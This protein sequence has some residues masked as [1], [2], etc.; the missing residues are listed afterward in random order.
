MKHL[1]RFKIL[2]PL[3]VMICMLFAGADTA[4]AAEYGNY[5]SS[6]S[7]LTVQLVDEHKIID[8]V[9][10][11]EITLVKTSGTKVKAHVLLV[12]PNAKA[13][14]KPVIPGY[15]TEGST[16]ATRTQKAKAW[17]DSSFSLTGVTNMIKQYE[18]SEGSLPVIAAV[19]GDFSNHP[20]NTPNGTATAPRGTVIMEGNSIAHS[21]TASDE[22]LFG[23]KSNGA[24]N[25]VGRTTSQKGLFEEAICGGAHILR[26]GSL[27]GVDNETVSDE[28][29]GIAIRNNGEVLLIT[30]ENGISVKQLAE[31]MQASGC[32]NGINMDGGGSIHMSTKRETETKLSRK[33]PLPGS[34][35]TVDDNGERQVTSALMLVA[36]DSTVVNNVKNVDTSKVTTDKDTYVRGE[37]I[38]VT[39]ST[40]V[41]GAWVSL[42][43]ES[44]SASA[45]SYFWYYVYGYS[46]VGSTDT[47]CW[48][49]GSTY[50]ILNDGI[51]SNREGVSSA[52]KLPLGKY[53]VSVL[54]YAE[55]GGYKELARSETITIK[56]DES[57]IE[58]ELELLDASRTDKQY[59]AT[60]NSYYGKTLY[61]YWYGD[62]IT[63]KASVEGDDSDG[64]WVGIVRD[65]TYNEGG[66]TCIS[67]NW[68]NVAELEGEEV[69]LNYVYKG[70]ISE[71]AKNVPRGLNY[72]AVLVSKTG[73]ILDAKPF[74]YRTYCLSWLEGEGTWA[75]QV[76]KNIKIE[77]RWI[78]K[79]VNGKDQKPEITITRINGHFGYEKDDTGKF[80]TDENGDFIEIT[81]EILVQ[82]KDYTVKYPGESKLAGS[83]NIE[84]IF[85]E[86]DNTDKLNY[87]NDKPEYYALKQGVTYYLTE[88]SDESIIE[89]NLNGGTNHKDNPALYKPGAEVKL[90]SPTRF[91]YCFDGWYTDADFSEGS[92][93]DRISKSDK[94]YMTLYAKWVLESEAPE[95]NTIEYVLYG[96]D[97][98]IKNPNKYTGSASINLAPAK[99]AGYTF[100]GWFYDAKF[101]I[102]VQDNVI[103][104]N[105][106]GGLKLHAKFVKSSFDITTDVENGTITDG[107]DVKNGESFTVEYAADGG[108]MLK[109][110][111]VDGIAVDINAHP[112]SYTFDK[113]D[114]DHDISVVFGK[115]DLAAPS[116]LTLQLSTAKNGYDNVK[117]SWNKVAGAAG[118]RIYYKKSTASKWNTV[119]VS[120]KVTYTTKNLATG[121][122]YNFRV[123]PYIK[124]GDEIIEADA[125]KS[126]T[127]T[128][129][130]K[131]TNVKVKRS[132]SKVKV[133]WT[134]I[135]GETGYQISKTLKK[136]KTSIV[137][138]YKTT[139]GKSK[140]VK[141]TKG[142]KYYY[143]VRAYKNVW[144][145]KKYVKVYGP[146]SVV[147]SF[148]R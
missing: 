82:G 54:T 60:K 142:K 114:S 69:N 34:G 8:G 90:K 52:A 97:D 7:D 102:P 144:N 72:W 125:Y 40:N 133:S 36:D 57:S 146:W 100:G 117:V 51:C 63:V 121:T 2:I 13:K 74:N 35:Y 147:K 77:P 123:V 126:S 95:K 87:L 27:F 86:S 83:Y 39:A 76:S 70:T 110:V 23:L 88:S 4:S 134:N 138:T 53:R 55:G 78:S 5:L 124:S 64:A 108:Y 12:K 105:S 19:S 32:I 112:T 143:K 104:K 28:R 119:R 89:Y 120:G 109:S 42:I 61:E 122:K 139:T 116:K 113:V 140:L 18:S 26:N 14:F 24:L 85:P 21:A 41:D 101:T 49:N 91:G 47:L 79:T 81:K 6:T 16:K 94:G 3:M 11:A 75:E 46:D 131:V 132:G 73:K 130:K 127:I 50:N 135:G 129:L 44:D 68:F 38:N 93:K 48:E 106:V 96:G 66:T 71:N 10:E 37:A 80:K 84:I 98:D 20:N 148:R 31:L 58:G 22:Y 33:T 17:T 118:Y 62:S 92:Q 30:V 1:K 111:T 15:Y 99:K 65:D 145:G 25:I 115:A 59:T 137:S 45:T 136:S 43:K 9:Y 103:Q 107:A 67:D 29:N 128:T 56:E 141:A